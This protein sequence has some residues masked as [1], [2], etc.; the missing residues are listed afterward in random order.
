MAL[1]G[2]GRVT[3]ASWPF[4]RL[5]PVP[6]HPRSRRDRRASNRASCKPRE[7]TALGVSFLWRSNPLALLVV[8]YTRCSGLHARS[9]Y[10][11][12][13]HD[14]GR[15]PSVRNCLRTEALPKGHPW[16]ERGADRR[17]A[18]RGGRSRRRAAKGARRSLATE[19]GGIDGRASVNMKR[20]RFWLDGRHPPDTP[21]V[22][23]KPRSPRPGLFICCV[24]RPFTG[25]HFRACAC[26]EFGW[27][28]Q[29]IP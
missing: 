12:M 29:R 13:N 25:N 10:V 15:S 17:G 24:T 26:A 22:L 2:S 11:L 1:V 14:E 6:R 8:P 16:P 4:R 7:W 28:S 21:S 9:L 19:R 23:L 3:S 5:T 20:L 18:I 27:Q